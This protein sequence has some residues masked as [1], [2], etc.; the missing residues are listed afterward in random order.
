M[1]EPLLLRQPTLD[2]DL[3]RVTKALTGA[4]AEVKAAVLAERPVVVVLDDGDLLGQG[5]VVDAALATGLL[6]LTR[7]FA[8]E[9]AKPGWRVNVVS[10]R[11]AADAEPV[12]AAAAWLAASGLSGQLVRVGSDHLGKV[13]P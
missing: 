3:D 13:W 6:G 2:G 10:H 12:R 4:F 7:A 9:G 1:P 11:C 8:L 5:D